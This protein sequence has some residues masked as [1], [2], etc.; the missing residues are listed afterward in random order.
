MTFPIQ[1]CIQG[2]EAIVLDVIQRHGFGAEQVNE[3]LELIH[4]FEIR[5]PFIGGFSSGKSSLINA[6]IKE[7]LLATDITPETAIATE[8]RAGT[9]RRFIGQ[10]PNE[11]D[12]FF[13][14]TQV[15]ENALQALA[16][17]GLLCIELENSPLQ[18]YPHLVLV[19]MPGW[20]SGVVAHHQVI[21]DYAHRSLAYIVVVSVGEGTLRDNIRQALLELAIKNKP[22]ILVLSKA[23]TK[24]PEDV[25]AVLVKVKAEI[26]DLMGQAPL[27]CVITSASKRDTAQ[28]EAALLQ[29][30]GQAEV[31]F[32]NSVAQPWAQELGRL[33]QL[34]GLL[35][36]QDFQDAEL[37]KAEIDSF[38][39][40][41]KEFDARLL[42]ETQ[43]LE[44]RVEP[45]VQAIE[46]RV[47][48]SLLGRL[49]GL[50]QRAIDGADIGNEVLA[51]ARLLVSQ[52]LR[53]E[54][55]PAMHRY[56]DRLA[57]ALPSKLDFNLQFSAPKFDGQRNTSS[58][59]DFGWKDISTKLAPF[60]IAIP[61]PLA[62]IAGVVLP[63]LGAIFGGG[64]K[65][66]Q[67][68]QEQAE[69]RR[70]ERAKGQVREAL[71][72]AA[73]EVAQSLHPM[74]Q[75][76]ITKAQDTVAKNIA[77]ERSDVEKALHAKR[78]ALQEGEEQAAQQ[79]Q[80]ATAD[81]QTLE[82]LQAQLPL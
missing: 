78:Q 70:Y 55:E 56:L 72:R 41:M 27:A 40:Q 20:G 74:L 4:N 26:Q 43:T 71:S 12:I 54:F 49:D 45:M 37:L 1:K 59:A 10:R 19:D 16:P 7:P 61:H 79:R 32:K 77:A 73:S 38:E 24:P 57:D 46:R 62:K 58:E 22:V 3:L 29:L 25:Q 39:D 30:E 64:N 82:K 35:S 21:D 53:E 31:V 52:A 2:Q 44:S 5:V 6:L 51:S 33:A 9:V 76:Q 34:L 50:T 65:T 8:L 11:S 60:L 13:T 23:H 14:Q 28:L 18:A 81:L 80:V 47:E 42:R 75:E 69:A 15:E 63:I 48:S 36:S 68:D 67:H 17:N 66:S